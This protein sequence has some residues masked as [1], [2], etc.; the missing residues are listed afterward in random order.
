[1]RRAPAFWWT[2]SPTLAARLLQPAGAVYGALTVRR[3]A[4]AGLALP[5]PVV[6]VGNLVA[7]GAGKTPTALALAGL[8]RDQGYRPAILSRG[9]GRDLSRSRRGTVIC[10]DPALHDVKTVGDE[11]LI[12]ATAAPTYVAVDRRRA[13]QQAMGD[14]ATLLILD[15]GLQNPALA[16]TLS[17]AVVDGASG[18]GNGLCVPA[19]PLRAPVSQQWPIVHA[20]CV[21]GE[22]Q[23]GDGVA[24]MA[25]AQGLPVL[26]ARLRPDPAVVEHLKGA[27]LLGF[28]GI[29]RPEK[30]FATLE[31][32]GLTLRG[33]RAF[34][35]HHTFTSEQRDAL[36]TEA[37]ALGA[38][39]VTT[40]KD[41]VRL[42]PDFPATVLPVILELEK[43]DAMGVL[44]ASRLPRV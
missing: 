33:R 22:G 12:L 44:L 21:I 16:K 24:E 28:A 27:P 26:R 19:G 15:D 39:L 32:C 34:P 38:Q 17:I 4:R 1:M 11:P 31:N 30:F 3:M 23:A 14:G 40:A 37:T 43:P 20:L 6:C 9:Y 7:G 8:L 13:A 35:D 41:R 2:G 42:P 18:I 10:V 25:V 5:V 36:R 29:G